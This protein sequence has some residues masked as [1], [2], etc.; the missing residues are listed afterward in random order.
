[1]EGMWGSGGVAPRKIS[2][3]HAL[4]TLEK[5]GKRPFCFNID[6]LADHLNFVPPEIPLAFL[7]K[8]NEVSFGKVRDHE[9]FIISTN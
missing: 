5:R 6:H 8:G 1:M 4:Q 7:C 2:R 3:G 9:M